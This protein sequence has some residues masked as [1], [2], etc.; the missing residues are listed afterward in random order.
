MPPP[1]HD[2]AVFERPY[3]L[4]SQHPY[5][6]DDS[7]SA[8]LEQMWHHDLIEHLSYLKDF[9]LCAPRL[10]KGEEPNLVRLEAPLGVRLRIVP[11]HRQTPP[12]EALRG[13]LGTAATLWHEIGNADVVHTSIMGWPPLDWITNPVAR[14]RRKRLLVV[15]ENTWRRQS[16]RKNWMIK[17]VAGLHESATE[18]MA[19]WSCNHADVALFTQ[20][21]FR[22]ALFTHGQGAA[23]VT[24]AV[25]VNQ[26]DILDPATAERLWARKL[27]EPVRLLLAGRLITAKGVD[28]LLS[29]LQMLDAR[30][31]AAR[32]D[33]IGEGDRRDACIEVAAALRSVRLSVLDPVPYG[34][35]F[36]KLLEGYHA[37]LIPSLTSEQ[38]RVLFDANAR[39]VPVIA[40]S[41]DG[42]R[43]HVKEGRTG[44]LLPVGDVQ[45]LA[46]AIERASASAP[47]LRTMGIAAVAAAPEFTHR[48]MHQRRS[49]IL[50]EH[51]A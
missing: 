20:P 15:V 51:L 5:Y 25:W 38:P 31:V 23:Y 49:S 7:G 43:P 13:L 39:A 47:E 4:V 29:A 21:S 27:T 22:D 28:V 8:W 26:E 10:P 3:L 30:G 19:R 14:L 16:R 17:T 50:R 46:A 1:S 35:P 34:A 40:S 44:W 18:V 36:L 45:A 9:T 33:I 11:L 41:T 42:L 2:F 37:L 24:P 6:Q 32:V 12:G 48:A